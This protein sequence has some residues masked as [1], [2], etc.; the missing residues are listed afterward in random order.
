MQGSKCL[1]FARP[2]HYSPGCRESVTVPQLPKLSGQNPYFS[3]TIRAPIPAMPFMQNRAWL[4]T[5]PREHQHGTRHFNA[6][7][8]VQF[9]V[10]VQV[11]FERLAMHSLGT[12]QASFPTL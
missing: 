10:A 6:A 2:F 5:K 7:L 11:T 3:G 12:G 9:V 8:V 4:S 1:S